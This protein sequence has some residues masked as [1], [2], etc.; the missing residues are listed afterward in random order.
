MLDKASIISSLLIHMLVDDTSVVLK[1]CSRT[2]L[3]SKL[4]NISQCL[5]ITTGCSQGV[6]VSL[7]RSGP[8]FLPSGDD[9]Q[10]GRV[11]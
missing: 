6:I 4:T 9:A 3:K 8:S 2:I 1:P 7:K 11:G 5:C 10:H